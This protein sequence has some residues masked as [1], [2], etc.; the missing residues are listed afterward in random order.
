[1]LAVP[2]PAIAHPV[3]GVV[4]ERSITP[5]ELLIVKPAVEE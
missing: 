2:L 5:V 1:M 4:V 3:A